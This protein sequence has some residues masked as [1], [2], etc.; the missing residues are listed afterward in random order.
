ML[1]GDFD[2]VEPL[3]KSPFVETSNALLVEICLVPPDEIGVGEKA[4]SL[5]LPDESYCSLSDHG[6]R[7]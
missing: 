4:V 5:V 1:S 6:Q 3:S 7:L 2:E